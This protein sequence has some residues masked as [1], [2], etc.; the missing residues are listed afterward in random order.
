MAYT[1]INKSSLHFNNKLYTGNSGTNAQTGVGFK[2]DWT[3]I[4]GR[5]TG[6]SHN[7]YDSVRGVTKIIKSNSNGGEDTQNTSLTAFGT[8]GFTLGSYDESNYNNA[9]YASWN[10]KAG[11]SFSNSAGANG[12]SIAST[13]SINTAAGFSIISYT[14]NGASSAT[15]AHGLGAV[16]KMMIVKR[17]DA[18]ASW[19]VYHHSIGANNQLKLDNTEASSA[20]QGAWNNTAPTSSLFTIGTAD[21]VNANNG[22]YIAYIFA[23]KQGYSKMGSYTGNGNADG[24]FC[25]LGFKPA[26]VM[27]KR[28]NNANFWLMRDNKRSPQNV[29]KKTLAADSASSEAGWG[30][31]YLIDMLSN[32][33]KMRDTTSPV[34]TSTATYIFQ[35]FAE[36]PLVGTNNVPCTAR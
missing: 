31:T 5:S 26:F 18:S 23:E 1:T 29:T 9:T 19:F 28:T 16:P 24:T 11:T 32:G 22:T 21:S 35:A 27:V 13:G 7:I 8:D 15:L 10:W 17:R 34:N 30:T 12:A 4:K 14:G 3:W 6:Y 36:A 20:N 2:P 33:F 25:Y